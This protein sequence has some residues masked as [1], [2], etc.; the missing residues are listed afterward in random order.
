MDLSQDLLGR[1]LRQVLTCAA[2]SDKCKICRKP[3]SQVRAC[4]RLPDAGDGNEGLVDLEVQILGDG[5]AHLT[6]SDSRAEYWIKRC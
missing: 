4:L 6:R 5:S 2:G 3:W 1:H